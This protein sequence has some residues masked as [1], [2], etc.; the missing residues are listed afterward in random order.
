[1]AEANQLWVWWQALLSVYAPVF[2]RP[3]WVR[4]VQWVTGMVLCW[5][6]HTLTQV[7]TALGL[8]ARWRVLEAF[9]E[10]G[11]WSREGVER[12]TMRLVEQERPARWGRYHPVALDDTKLHRTSAEV[13]GTCTFHEPSA[14]SP[15]R[16]ETVRA[17]NWVVLGD[18][19]PGRPW[20]F[21]PQAAR[22]YV[23]QSQ[24]PT[25]ERFQTKP[26]LGVEMLRQAN[27]ES[28][29][30][31]LAV[32]D[33]AYAVESVVTPCL[34]PESGQ[35]RIEILTRLRVDA[36]L[37]HPPGAQAQP[38]GRPRKWG[39]RLA[40]PQCHCQWHVPWHQEQAWIYGRVRTFRYRQVRCYWVVSGSETPVHALVCKV[41]GYK[42]PWFLVTTALDLSPA[43][44]V[45]AY[46]ARFRQEDAFRDH[47]QRLGMEECRAWTKEPVL[48]TFQ[49]QM[50][51]L[52]LLRVLQ[53]RLD[54]HWGSGRWWQPPPWNP[55]KVRASILDLRRLLWRYRPAF[56]HFLSALE[57]REKVPQ[58]L[59]LCDE[60]IPLAA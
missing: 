31:L 17:H 36:R 30:P 47:K 27:A 28:A 60:S 10:Y 16:A 40:A 54:E 57:D 51:A 2:T 12:R 34:N 25:G 4:F 5:E 43:Q 37:Y 53:W 13:W 35:P 29:A 23:R 22:L 15:N 20:T 58:S 44:V 49:V 41:A 1:M 14:R 59:P 3:G 19:V 33:G 39:P 8:E 11:A 26:A 55:R 21:L 52:T 7:L 24:L 42:R 45:A 50:V 32:C 9:A 6:E 56:S 46:A 18:L 48:R 38:K